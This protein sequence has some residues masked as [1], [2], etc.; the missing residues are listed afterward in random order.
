M[1]H[2]NRNEDY[3]TN[4]LYTFDRMRIGLSSRWGIEAHA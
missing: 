1:F 2:R 3:I 4:K